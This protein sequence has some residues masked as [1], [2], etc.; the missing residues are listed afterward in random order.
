MFSNLLDE[1]VELELMQLGDLAQSTRTFFQEELPR[2]VQ[3]PSAT[4]LF[5]CG[6]RV[7]QSQMFGAY[8]ALSK[9]FEAAPPSVGFNVQYEIYSGFQI[10]TTLT[11]LAFGQNDA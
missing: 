4:V 8:D 5:H 11:V 2:R 1:G 6:G 3:N 7:F 9:S 10:N